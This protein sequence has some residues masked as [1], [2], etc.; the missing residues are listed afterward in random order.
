MRG[1]GVSL[2]FVCEDI[3]PRVSSGQTNRHF[4]LALTA[5]RRFCWSLRSP[6]NSAI[7][8]TEHSDSAQAFAF[9]LKIL[10]RMIGR[11]TDNVEMARS[12]KG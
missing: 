12:K 8:D 9:S 6:R 4:M 2:V 11:T 7:S 3:V 1:E 5:V 10:M